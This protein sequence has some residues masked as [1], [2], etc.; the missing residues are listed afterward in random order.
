VKNILDIVPGIVAQTAGKLLFKDA[1]LTLQ[2][3]G[4]GSSYDPTPGE[5]VSYPCRAL[6]TSWSN[7]SISNGLVASQDR[8]I[9]IAAATLKGAAPRDGASI[10]IDGEVYVLVSDS[11]S[12]PAVKRD[13]ANALWICRGRG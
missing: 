1:V 7:F 4:S 6:V 10:E 12:A 9:L 3:K 5:D 2:G 8:K 11:G 13:P